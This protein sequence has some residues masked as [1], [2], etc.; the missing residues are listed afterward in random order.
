MASI[1]GTMKSGWCLATILSKA[2]IQHVITSKSCAALLV[3]FH[4]CQL[5]YNLA[6]S[7]RSNRKFF[8]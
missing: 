6:N 2:S 4:N 1:S 3:L 8:A 7:L 5:Q